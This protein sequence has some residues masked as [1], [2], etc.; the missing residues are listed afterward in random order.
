[1]PDSAAEP[2]SFRP[3]RRADFSYW[4][5]LLMAA[6]L[7]VWTVVPWLFARSLPLDVVSD[8][9]AW[10][11]EWQWGYYKHPPLPSWTVEAFFDAFG[12]I[13]PFLL[14]QLSIAATYIFV[15]ALG[16]EMMGARRAAVGTLLLVGVYY[17]SIPTPEFNH[18][19]AQMP[20][21]AAACLCYYRAWKTGEMR[22]WLGLGTVAGLGLLT[23]Y[24]TAVLL[25]VMLAHFV[26]VR[27]ARQA[28]LSAG[29]WLAAGICLLIISMHVLW[30]FNNGFPTLH[31]A[32]ARAGATSAVRDRVIVPL[33]FLA[34]QGVDIGPAFLLAWISGLRPTKTAV[35]ADGKLNFLLWM[36]LGPPTV[37]V[38]GSLLIGM[39]VRDM[40]G[41]PMW[42]LTG[43]AIVLGAAG[44][45]KRVKL[46]WLG[47]GAVVLF[48]I[49]VAGFVLANVLVPERENRPSRIQWPDRALAET[50]ETVWRQQIHRHL[51]IV[52]AD[53]WLGGLVAMRSLPRPSVWIDADYH[54]A[55]WITTDLVMLD[56][57]LVLWRI[58]PGRTE[59]KGVTALKGLRIIGQKTFVWPDAPKAIPLE[60]GYAILPPA[61]R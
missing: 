46:R 15:F 53:G 36:T 21:W 2:Q 3:S 8:G 5:A 32:A 45:W 35:E 24:S 42:N 22:W 39:G 27:G 54:K 18:N 1:M 11:H 33:K 30:L 47:A 60:I 14:S 17:F 43:L 40:W 52:A 57:A 58:Q 23:K 20:L 25:F 31:Y 51:R 6:Q 48:C 12:D 16:R 13:G 61:R 38:L 10:G 41:A 28:L 29:A 59:P 55:P 44:S 26:T 50:F 34:A 49:G 7:L 19:V 56:G 4:L 9:L 37:T